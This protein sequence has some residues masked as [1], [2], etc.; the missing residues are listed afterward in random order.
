MNTI[1]CGLVL[2]D[3]IQKIQEIK[4][5]ISE[6]ASTGDDYGYVRTILEFKMN[7]IWNRCV[8]NRIHEYPVEAYRAFVDSEIKKEDA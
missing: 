2:G 7:E 3:A 5:A 8:A 4:D 1:R 6:L